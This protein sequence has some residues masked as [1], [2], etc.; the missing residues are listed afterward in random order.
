MLACV[1]D[2]VHTKSQKEDGGEDSE[3]HHQEER[4]EPDMGRDDRATSLFGFLGAAVLVNPT[5]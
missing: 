2:E 1:Q 5:Q 4:K 3:A